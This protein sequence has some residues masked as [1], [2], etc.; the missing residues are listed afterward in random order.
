MQMKEM[1]VK[2]WQ[3]QTSANTIRLTLL[4]CGIPSMKFIDLSLSSSALWC[5]IWRRPLRLVGTLSDLIMVTRDDLRLLRPDC[6]IKWDGKVDENRSNFDR[7]IDQNAPKTKCQYLPWLT[8]LSNHY[9]RPIRTPTDQ[10]LFPWWFFFCWP[11]VVIHNRFPENVFNPY[12]ISPTISTE[13]I[14]FRP[15]EI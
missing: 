7:F 4:G 1:S 3:L 9:F 6:N 8:N 15:I 13:M 5:R 2:N 14:N 12:T 11:V 10:M